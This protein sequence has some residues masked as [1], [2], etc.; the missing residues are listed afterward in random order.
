MRKSSEAARLINDVTNY[1]IN[2]V[3][4]QEKEE[5]KT[6]R[7][8]ASSVEIESRNCP[9]SATNIV[10]NSNDYQSFDGSCNN[11]DNQFFGKSNTPYKRLLSPEYGDGVNSPRT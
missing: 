4:N 9:F 2:H 1:V 7:E 10:C 8:I 11:L 6:K 5:G 3:E